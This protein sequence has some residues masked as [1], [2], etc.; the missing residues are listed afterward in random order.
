M[1]DLSGIRDQ[2]YTAVVHHYHRGFALSD[3]YDDDVL[4][5]H[6]IIKGFLEISALES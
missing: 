1:T 3:I 5:L 6:I 2:L 4:G